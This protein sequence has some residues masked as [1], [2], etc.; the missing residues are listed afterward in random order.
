LIFEDQGISAATAAVLAV[1]ATSAIVFVWYKRGP[2]VG[3][4]VAVALAVASALVLLLPPLVGGA[5]A[6]VLFY[7]YAIARWRRMLLRASEVTVRPTLTP[8]VL[9][10]ADTRVW[11]LGVLGFEPPRY[12]ELKGDG[13]PVYLAHLL[14]ETGTMRASVQWVPATKMVLT[15]S[16]VSRFPAGSV[17]TS[18]RLPAL[19]PCP[20]DLLQVVPKA[21]AEQLLTAQRSAVELLAGHGLVAVALPDEPELWR[22]ED[23]LH[24]LATWIR[25]RPWRNTVVVMFSGRRSRR[26][27]FGPLLAQPARDERIAALVA[28]QPAGEP[29]ESEGK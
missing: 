5:L 28:M 9:A 11:N 25:G 6:G 3:R 2:L 10:E 15:R 29:E 1:V 8:D 17:T 12:A 26:A 7:T 14:H 21:S 24:R 16:I 18:N 19:D 22:L 23:E 4:R 20:G 13:Q 27:R